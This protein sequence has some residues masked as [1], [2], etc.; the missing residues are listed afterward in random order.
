MISYVLYIHKIGD[1]WAI[2][3]VCY[4]LVSGKVPFY[5][6]NQTETLDA[7]KRGKFA[8]PHN[9]N[10]SDSCK[11]FISHLLET[12]VDKRFDAKQALN[13]EWI[14]EKGKALSI[15]FGD[16]HLNEI[17][18]FTTANK[19]QKILL[20][21]ILSEMDK[22]EK[23]ILLTALRDLDM[24]GN[25]EI[26]ETD[27]INYVLMHKSSANQL[28]AY[29]I[30]ADLHSKSYYQ[31]LKPNMIMENVDIDGILDEINEEDESKICET[32][33]VINNPSNKSI[34]SGSSKSAVRER[35]DMIDDEDGE[36]DDFDID[37]E[38]ENE[39]EGD[40]DNDNDDNDHT[41][42]VQQHQLQF[43]NFS[44]AQTDSDPDLDDDDIKIAIATKNDTKI[45]VARFSMLLSKA[46]KQYDIEDLVDRLEPTKSGNIALSKINKFNGPLRSEAS[47]D[48]M[49]HEFVTMG[50]NMNS[51]NSNMSSISDDNSK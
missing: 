25:K 41:D 7:I 22:K 50:L 48:R 42:A 44:S 20:N 23:R 11:N 28:N 10:L 1:L 30:N 14:H 6:S 39:E 38:E 43:Y 51:N 13:H 24:N 15:D 12:N 46:D 19:L 45:S 37:Q 2:G 4:I 9:V 47:N 26:N 18:S 5:G 3:V 16:G 33:L 34:Q 49:M 8:W 21:A 40:E 17:V 27:I 36:D 31:K 29:G 32:H 35:F